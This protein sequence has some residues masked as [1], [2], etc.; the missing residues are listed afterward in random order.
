MTKAATAREVKYIMLQLLQPFMH[1][2]IDF[3]KKINMHCIS[4]RHIRSII[5]VYSWY[6]VLYYIYII[7]C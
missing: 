6:N 1:T 4:T 2:Y 5:Y 3:E 7:Y